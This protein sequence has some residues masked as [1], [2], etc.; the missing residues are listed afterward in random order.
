MNKFLSKRFTLV[1]SAFTVMTYLGV[2]AVHKEMDAVV[3]IVV[4]SL[5]GIITW[6]INQE[7]KR[8]SK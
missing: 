5:A 3:V 6:Y 8:P 7:T 4:G 1:V 2:A